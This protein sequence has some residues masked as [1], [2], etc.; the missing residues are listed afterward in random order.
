MDLPDKNNET[1]FKGLIAMMEHLSEPWGIKDL[2]SRHI[3]MN[4][5]AFLY[6]N[7]PLDFEVEGKMDHEFPGN[8]TEFAPDLIEHD[9]RTEETQDRVTVIETHYWYG[10]NTLTPFI[11]EKLPVYNDRKEVIGVMWNAKPFNTLS[12]LKYIN[13][14]KPSILTTEINN[15]MFTRAE[16]DVI[17]LMLQRLSVKEIAKIY[18][19]STKTIEN[20][21]YA[22]YQKSDV[23]TLQQFEE[24][25]KFAHLDNYIP[26]RLVAKGIQFI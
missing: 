24:F 9:K 20:R 7:T 12:P 8:W 14:Q 19:I 18:N 23:H 6:T 3:Y 26:D 2:N 16:L 15:S 10:K 11:S 25:C 17:F 13:Q 4:K 22:I 21:I 1:Y 5:A